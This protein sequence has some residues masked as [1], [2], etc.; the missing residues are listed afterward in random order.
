MKKEKKCIHCNKDNSEG[1]FYCR[2]CGEKASKPLYTTQFIVRENNPWAT[3]IRK[4]KIDFR[5]ESVES[6]V[7]RMR[8]T[9]W[10]TV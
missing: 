3:A 9:K 7:K 4:D 1:W 2:S 5:T 10:G 8:K 6:S